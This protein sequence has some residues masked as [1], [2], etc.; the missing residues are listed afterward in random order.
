[1]KQILMSVS[2]TIVVVNITVLT[3]LVAISADVMMDM[4]CLMIKIA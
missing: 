1:M 3:L 2:V 4:S